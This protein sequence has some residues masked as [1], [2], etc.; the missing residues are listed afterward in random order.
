[1]Y[2]RTVIDIPASDVTIDHTTQMML[3][4][5]CFSENIGIKLGEYK[6]KVDVNPFG[7]LYNPS[8]IIASIERLLS[9]KPF[10]G[11]DLVCHNGIYHSLM[12]HGQFSDVN[13]SVCLQSIENR[14]SKAAAEIA[15]TDVFLI[16][17]GSAY[18]YRW[19]ESSAIVGNCHKIPAAMFD[20][21][22]LS[23]NEIIEEWGTL[24][25]LLREINPSV[26]FLF[27][28][29]P[30]RHWK[31]GVHENQLSKSILH[32]AVDNLQQ[33]FPAQVHYFSAFELMM[34]EL[35]DYRFYG[36]DMI[37]PSTFA[38]EYIWNRFADTYFSSATKAIN[39]EWAHIS[40]SLGHRP[41]YPETAAYRAFEKSILLKLEDFG[42]KYPYISCDEEIAKLV[43]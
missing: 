26:K 25:S 19:K 38:V 15:Q 34:D 31:E 20:R 21:F 16:T 4:G 10:T 27:T 30:V 23:V 42:R 2:F 8:S 18:A 3:F 11:D 33:Q 7:I 40:K 29:S 22:R 28:V 41:L 6:F 37:H 17:F 36:D 9:N 43:K 13:Q 1:M 32:L 12:H 5:S 35:R 39:A 14:F 24:I